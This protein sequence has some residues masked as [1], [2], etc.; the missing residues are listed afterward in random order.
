MRNR[1]G[2]E[3]MKV[4]ALVLLLA[5]VGVAGGTWT[6]E[7]AAQERLMLSRTPATVDV[8][9]GTPGGKDILIA[10]GTLQFLGLVVFEAMAYVRRR[11]QV[12]PSA[13]LAWRVP[14]AV[15]AHAG[16]SR[17]AA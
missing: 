10:I 17:Q 3:S 8:Q 4:G 13:P 7:A 12:R 16:H 1:H 6:G 11:T 15:Q 5:V 2:R 9:A 14:V